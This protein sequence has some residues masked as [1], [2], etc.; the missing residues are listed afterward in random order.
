MPGNLDNWG[1]GGANRNITTTQN[2][3][4]DDW[5]LGSPNRFLSF[6][7]P[8]TYPNALDTW[9]LGGVSR[10]L[11]T[12][13]YGNLDS[14]GK[15]GVVHWLNAIGTTVTWGPISLDESTRLKVYGYLEL[16]EATRLKAYEEIQFDEATRLKAY[17]LPGNRS[18]PSGLQALLQQEV[19]ALAFC[20]KISRKDGTTLGFTSCDHDL[21]INGLNYQAQ[22]SGIPET[23]QQEI[24]PSVD[25]LTIQGILSSDAITEA[26]ILSGRYDGAS[27]EIFIV[28]YEDLGLGVWTILRGFLGNVQQTSVGYAVEIRSLAQLLQQPLGSLTSPT[29]RVKKLGDSRC[30]VNLAPFTFTN[31]PVVEVLSRA[32]FSV[33]TPDFLR[34]S[35][36]FA[37]GTVVFTSGNNRAIE[38]EVKSHTR[39]DNGMSELLLQEAFPQTIVEGDLCTLVVGCDRLYQTCKARFDN[40]VNFRG[41]PHL[42]GNDK[43]LVRGRN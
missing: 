28:C 9:G 1:L 7:P 6:I 16:D 22:G 37:H 8:P 17:A 15:Q 39:K 19:G 21:L 13:P 34:A 27:A 33:D 4:L 24:G 5:G 10:V 40:A 26:D 18:I 30:K 20:V 11:G 36:N 35:D 38:R 42:P 25:N 23:L 41:E 31:L 3:D 12:D 14:W 2:T 29:C 32:Q 43:I